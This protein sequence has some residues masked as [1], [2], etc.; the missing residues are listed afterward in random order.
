MANWTSVNPAGIN[1]AYPNNQTCGCSM[2]VLAKLGGGYGLSSLQLP[3]GSRY[4]IA[5]DGF[6]GGVSQIT[7]PTGGWVQFGYGDAQTLATCVYTRPDHVGFPYLPCDQIAATDEWRND[8]STSSH[9]SYTYSGAVVNN[10]VQSITT[11]VTDPLGQNAVYSYA[12]EDLG[13]TSGASAWDMLE[14]QRKVLSAVGASLRTTTTS[15][16]SLPSTGTPMPSSIQTALGDAPG[17]LSSEVDFQYDSFGNRVEEDDHEFAA[18]A[19][20]TPP[21]SPQNSFGCD[22]GPLLKKATRAFHSFANGVWITDRPDSETTFDGSGNPLAGTTWEYDV[23]TGT[24]H[25]PLVASTAVDHDPAYAAGAGFT[26]RG[27]A[28]AISRCANFSGST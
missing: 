25:A 12:S 19:A 8:G 16:V 21:A 28:T 18:C 5:Y 27:N 9:W 6:S 15:Y 17:P 26:T 20:P 10:V 3:D 7:Y 22:P 24:N 13:S 14:T 23:Y 4:T 2:D 11:T 1:L